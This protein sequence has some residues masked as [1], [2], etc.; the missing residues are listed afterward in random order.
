MAMS[1]NSSSDGQETLTT[2][3]RTSAWSRRVV[4]RKGEMTKAAVDRGWPHQVALAGSQVARDYYVILNF[5]KAEHL[6]FSGRGHSFRRDKVDYV[7]KCFATKED[8]DKFT[9]RFGGEYMMPTTR[10]K[11]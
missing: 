4:Y 10:P 2:V 8:A 6:S 7:L 11:F 1:R 5:C 3:L 9:E